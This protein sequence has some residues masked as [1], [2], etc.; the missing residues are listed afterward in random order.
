MPKEDFQSLCL[1]NAESNAI[2]KAMDA[3]GDKLDLTKLT[4]YPCV[5]PD[6]G[7]SDQTVE[8]ALVMLNALVERGRSTKKRKPWWKFW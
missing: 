3:A 8:E 4:M 6:R 1:Y 7:V 2:M 5:V